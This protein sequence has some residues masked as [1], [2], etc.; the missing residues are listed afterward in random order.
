ME[1]VKTY[2]IQ[3]YAKLKDL[4]LSMT[5]GNRIVAALLAAT[6]FVSLGY[7]IAGSIK[8]AD[9]S[10]K[11]V[12]LYNGHRFDQIQARAAED[13][14]A[15]AG[16][17]DYQWVGDRIQVA[18]DRLPRYIAELAK[19]NIT[20]PSS[21]PRQDTADSFSPFHHAKIMDTRMNAASERTTSAA[22][23]WLPGIA[24]AIVQTH[25]RPDWERN[26]WARKNVISVSVTLD[27]ISRTPLPDETIVAVGNIVAPAFGITNMKEIRIVD[28]RNSKSY[29]GFGNEVGSAQG[30]YFRH[31]LRHQAEWNKRIIELLPAIEG[32]EVDTTVMLTTYRER[33]SLNVQH[34]RPTILTNHQMNYEFLREGYNRFFRPGQVA[35]WGSPLINPTGDETPSDRTEER[36]IESEVTNAL[37]G[38]ETNEEVLPYI[39][40]RISASIRI[41]RDYVVAL[42]RDTNRQMGGDPDAIPTPEA[43][44]ALEEE[45]SQTYRELVANLIGPHLES[46]REDPMDLVTIAF[47]QRILPVEVELTA[48]EQFVLFLK[49]NW[50]NLGLMSLVF[51]GL[52]VLWLI[53]KPQKP[54]SIVLYEGLETPLEA[55]DARI[56]EKIRREEEAAAAAAAEEEELEEF[57]NTLGELGSLRSLRDEIAELIARNP[58]AAAAVIRQWVGTSV[59]VE[60]KS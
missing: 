39:P 16:L 23:K 22:I 43:L 27:T 34:D 38:T 14:F 8:Q 17:T 31:Q 3:N 35:Q 54:E 53:S 46:R 52:A 24:D 21:T 13:A 51:S 57:E 18:R 25:K 36:R 29:D 59:L 49:E 19:E 42:W 11:T 60:A 10:S 58:E 9:V 50:Q 55:I 41:P 44:R 32:L 20:A 6:L 30:E 2:F 4:Y 5:L 28:V 40:L 1:Q 48:W 37:P 56:A 12:F 15:I 26:V 33:R 47:V 7:L 45:I